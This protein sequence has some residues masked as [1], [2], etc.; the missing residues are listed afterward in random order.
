MLFINVLNVFSQQFCS[1]K[2]I[3][4]PAY[5]TITHITI[6][7]FDNFLYISTSKYASVIEPG[8]F[9]KVIHIDG[10]AGKY[11]LNEGKILLQQ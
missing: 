11:L 4:Y 9:T 8:P 7:S 3:L 6:L 5:K 10:Q 2:I 1:Q